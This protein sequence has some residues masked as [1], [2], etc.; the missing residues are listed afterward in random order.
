MELV[1]H[2]GVTTDTEKLDARQQ[3]LFKMIEENKGKFE[4][5]DE[6]NFLTPGGR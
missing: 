4:E 2:L 5:P 3:E 6:T 1:Y